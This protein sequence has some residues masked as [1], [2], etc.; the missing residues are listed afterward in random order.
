VLAALRAK[1]VDVHA[2]GTACQ[3]YERAGLVGRQG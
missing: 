2:Q 1:L 3:I